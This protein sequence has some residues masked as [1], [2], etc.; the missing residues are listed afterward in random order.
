MKMLPLR[1]TF[2]LFLFC[3]VT[4]GN[5]ECLSSTNQGNS[6]SQSAC[7]PVASFIA[8]R[9]LGVDCSLGEV[10]S[11][12]GYSGE[13]VDVKSIYKTLNSFRG[14]K[15]TLEKLKNEELLEH[16]KQND[17]VALLLVKKRADI[18][19][20]VVSLISKQGKLSF[21]DYPHIRKNF[22][23]A[24]FPQRF[25]TGDCLM[26]KRDG[27]FLLSISFYVF[28]ACCVLFFYSIAF[29]LRHTREK[30]LLGILLVAGL[31]S[32]HTCTAFGNNEFNLSQAQKLLTIDLGRIEDKDKVSTE[33]YII[34]DTLELLTINNVKVACSS[35]IKPT[36]FPD[37]ISPG[38]KGCF[39]FDIFTKRMKG[40]IKSLA[41]LESDEGKNLGLAF[42]GFIPCIWSYPDRFEMGNIVKGN[43]IQK[44]NLLLSMGYPDAKIIKI[45]TPNDFVKCTLGKVH[46]DPNRLHKDAFCLGAL[47]LQFDTSHLELGFFKQEVILKTNIPY[48]SNIR[49]PI[50]GYLQGDVKLYPSKLI[51][52]SI[53]A[54]E[55][56]EKK[57]RAVLNDFQQ[58]N[59]RELKIQSSHPWIKA[60][61]SDTTSVKSGKTQIIIKATL[62]PK[63]MN[64]SIS[65]G[66]LTVLHNSKAIFRIPYFAFSSHKKEPVQRSP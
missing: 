37:K 57:C 64:E 35:C 61:I 19:N 26:V 23:L 21:I 50:M 56:V 8:L 45:I 16:L 62:T 44:N 6:F 52:S 29:L 33:V 28:L 13:P 41:I 43:V 24:E 11:R 36:S 1:M 9:T 31:L 48:Y 15:C 60:E 54:E 27:P 20:H 39:R 46:I 42:I 63:K 47:T 14:I 58:K 4:F 2:T 49:V 18:I 10:V 22:D 5:S 55:K 53:K 3:L 32:Y 51:F 59:S 12:C 17:C 40:R 30:K 25:W 65:K 38:T 66:E 7:G 34:N